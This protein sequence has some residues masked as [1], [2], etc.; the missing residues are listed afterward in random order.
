MI[1]LKLLSQLQKSGKAFLCH[2]TF[3]KVDEPQKEVEVQRVHSLQED[4][5]ALVQFENLSE[6]WTD[7]AQNHFMSGDKL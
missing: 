6:E 4:Q 5:R 7:G 1:N 3:S 2:L